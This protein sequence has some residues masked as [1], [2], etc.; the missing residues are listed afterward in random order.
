MRSLLQAVSLVII[1]TVAAFP[2]AADQPS[3]LSSGAPAVSADV[4][5]AIFAPAVDSS[6]TL[7]GKPVLAIAPY[8]GYCSGTCQPCYSGNTPA[9]PPDFE[10]NRQFCARQR[11]C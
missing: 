1:L 2:A 8:N 11:I 6:T 4:F 7:Q 3:T 10:G 9:C 5:D